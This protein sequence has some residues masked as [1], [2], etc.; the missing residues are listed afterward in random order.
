MLQVS[1]DLISFLRDLLKF[2]LGTGEF[3][4]LLLLKPARI[5][6]DE[7]IMSLACIIK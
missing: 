1:S 3:S 5:V 6:T 2:V 7:M 4:Q